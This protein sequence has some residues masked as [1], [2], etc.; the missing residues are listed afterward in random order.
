MIDNGFKEYLEEV[1]GRTDA[2]AA[3]SAFD[4]PASVS[5]RLNPFKTMTGKPVWAD[6]VEGEV[7]WSSYGRML[8]RR[9][10]FTLDPY[11]HAGAYYVQDSSSM[12][13]GEMFR[14]VLECLF[15]D[16]L[17]S[18]R[19]V[20]VLDLCAAPGGKATDLAASLREFCGDGFILVAN[21]VMK[22]RAGVLADNLAVWGD[23]NVIVAN[24]DPSAFAE[25]GGY[26]DVILA[27]VPCSGEGMFRKDPEAAA[28]WSRDNVDLCQ[29]RQRRI[30]AD[31]WPA[32]SEGGMLIYSTCTF[33]RRENDINAGWI[34]ENLGASPAGETEWCR[35][36]ADGSTEGFRI[37][38]TEF[39]FSLLPGLVRGEGQ[40]CCALVRTSDNASDRKRGCGRKAGLP[41]GARRR[42]AA[43]GAADGLE[44]MFR[45][46]VE[47][48]QKDRFLI[49]L[50]GAVAEEMEAV[51]SVLHPI[52]VGC[53]AGEVKGN[54][55]VPAADLALSYMFS[56][57][58]F[59]RAELDIANALAFLHRD[60][61]LL[62]DAPKGYVAVC[63]GGLPVGFVKNIGTRCNN[64][65]PQGRRIRMDINNVLNN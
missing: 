20:R 5:V 6:S 65:H 19:P 34:I 30:V 58:A 50:P 21:E 23:P 51:A 12:F 28:Q 16:G 47:L 24:A 57:E 1:A 29:V 13:V 44:G 43:R 18:G 15:H 25:L 48:R 53:L 2:A 64:L 59:P 26:F 52:H 62:P 49:A 39:G 27:D 46:P 8:G 38:E 37:L 31:V 32:L 10:T 45:V 56:D 3:F 54:D 11:L 14:M 55:L 33:N 9:H 60:G 7:P 17:P 40:Y 61:I 22:S 4:E 36:Y 41:G 35:K 42:D 63:Y